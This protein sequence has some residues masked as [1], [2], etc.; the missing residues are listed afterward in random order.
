MRCKRASPSESE[1]ITTHFFSYPLL[2][3]L[4][5]TRQPHCP[6]LPPTSPHAPHTHAGRAGS[7]ESSRRTTSSSSSGRSCRLTRAATRCHQ[8]P[9]PR[10][11]ISSA[12][13]R[14]RTCTKRSRP[15]TRHRT[16]Q[17]STSS[18]PRSVSTRGCD[19][20]YGA[21]RWQVP[22]RPCLQNARDSRP[23]FFFLCS[24]SPNIRAAS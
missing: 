5:A 14:R 11:P 2:T 17:T 13:R 6:L 15:C 24:Y 20:E 10:G 7:Y 19:R 22:T 8:M 16:S 23:L 18:T 3:A 1:F 4:V 9:E 21:T 12:R